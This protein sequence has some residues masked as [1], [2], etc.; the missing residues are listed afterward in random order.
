MRTTG[1]ELVH[2]HHLA[3]LD[4]A[5]PALARAAG[6][7]VV[8]T[9]HDYHLLCVRGQLVNRELQ[10]CPGP[11]AARCGDCVAE[12]LAAP[13]ALRR[14]A[15]LLSRLRPAQALGRR[16]LRLAGP[17]ARG[18]SALEERFTA[19][20][21]ALS[22]AH[23]VLAPSLDLAE[24]VRTLGWAEQVLVQDLPLV[25]PL[26]EQPAGEGPLRFLFV[27]S[28]IP[29]K[30]PDVLVEAFRGA[31]ARLRRDGTPEDRLPTLTLWGPRPDFD[32]A[33]GYADALLAELSRVPG[34]RYGGIFD[35]SQREAV[36]GSADVLVLPSIWEENSPLVV[37]EAR[38][39][40]LRVVASAV[41]GIA[42]I[43]PNAR[44]TAPKDPKA[45]EAALLSENSL[46][47]ARRPTRGYSMEEHISAL[48]AH[49][50]AA[51]SARG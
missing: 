23:R 40:G 34:A 31:V 10:R 49:Y 1:A 17:G 28:L 48:L 13:T 41:G 37:R 21:T 18:Q 3:H 51:L 35:D 29:T 24:R 9:L 38:A 6:A 27:G 32:G 4:L 11:S 7:G 42:E 20:K 26:R 43:D 14:L 44:L 15:P 8:W 36:Y 19:A 39:A 45:L 25:A 22:A 46:G 50:H 2:F 16:V 30:G 47:R 33:P 12:H 5:L